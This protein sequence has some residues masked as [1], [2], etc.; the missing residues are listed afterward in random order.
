MDTW[1]MLGGPGGVYTNFNGS[2]ILPILCGHAVE[3]LVPEEMDIR[4]SHGERTHGIC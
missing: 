4:W 3:G 2:H 1:R